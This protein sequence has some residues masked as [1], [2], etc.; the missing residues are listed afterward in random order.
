MKSFAIIA[1]AMLL[2]AS[3]AYAQNQ[4]N[5]TPSNGST[6][7]Q[8][9]MSA[10]TQPDVL[11]DIP[12]LTVDEIT[13]EVDNLQAHIALDAQLA[14]LVK[15]TA[16]ADASID[17][18]KLTIKG[19]HAQATLVVRLENVRAILE[20]TLQTIDQNPE[21]VKGLFS[22]VNNTVGTAAGVVNRALPVVG[23]IGNK[24]VDTLGSAAN[25]ALPA[26]G[27]TLNN[28]VGTVGGVATSTLQNGQVLDLARSSLSE[29]SRATNAT[30]QIVRQVRDAAGNLT[31]VTTDQAGRIVSSRRIAR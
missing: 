30:G 3:P 5:R 13:L 15:L 14:N 11:L 24:T 9:A 18:V 31:E 20:R 7:A 26:V 25:R 6:V 2:A 29:V 12:D 19:V 10:S 1:T 17:K 27:S 8:Q 23:S 22:T 16:G 28:T 21:I 4:R